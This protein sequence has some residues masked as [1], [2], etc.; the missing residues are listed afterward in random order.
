MSKTNPTAAALSTATIVD[1]I[2][3]RATGDVVA[4]DA[5]AFRCSCCGARI[6]ILVCV[7]TAAGDDL[8]IGTSCARRVGLRAIPAARRP[9]APRTFPRPVTVAGGRA[10]AAFAAAVGAVAAHIEEERAAAL[11]ARFAGLGTVG[12]EVDLM[13]LFDAC[14]A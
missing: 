1:V 12:G 13:A 3:T 14:A 5:P 7:S 10:L 2:D 11:A 8:T 9:N 6:Y 4:D